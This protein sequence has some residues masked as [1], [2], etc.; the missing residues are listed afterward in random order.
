MGEVL[1]KDKMKCEAVVQLM[2]DRD[3]ALTLNFDEICEYA[4]NATT[5][6]NY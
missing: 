6:F 2:S 5:D 3:V 1:R 4:G